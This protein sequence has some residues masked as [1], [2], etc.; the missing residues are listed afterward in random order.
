MC[1][2]TS[3]AIRN[4][5]GRGGV[6]LSALETVC[7]ALIQHS[8]MRH[9]RLTRTTVHEGVWGKEISLPCSHHDSIRGSRGIDPLIHNIG[10][11]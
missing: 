3:S 5:G 2:Q 11:A 10:T 8:A 4:G 9:I 7:C 1:L 6:L